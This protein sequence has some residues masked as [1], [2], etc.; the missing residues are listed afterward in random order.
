MKIIR[1][2]KKGKTNPYVGKR[3]I[4]DECGTVFE[5]EPEDVKKIKSEPVGDVRAS[6]EGH[7]GYFDM[8]ECLVCHNDVC[9]NP[10]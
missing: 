5:I 4:C 10:N 1:R 8:I 6:M 7:S 3:F 2:G 9:L